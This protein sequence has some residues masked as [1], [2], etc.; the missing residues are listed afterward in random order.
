MDEKEKILK[1][2]DLA[3]ERELRFVRIVLENMLRQ[4]PK[5]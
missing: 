5:D 4:N 1:L 3:G 2:L